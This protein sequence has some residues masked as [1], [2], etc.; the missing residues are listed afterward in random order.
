MLPKVLNT[1]TRKP[2]L[3]TLALQVLSD[4]ISDLCPI[5]TA[6]SGSVSSLPHQLPTIGCCAALHWP[7]R[8]QLPLHL[9]SEAHFPVWLCGPL[10]QAECVP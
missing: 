9:L 2:R 7:L 8:T 3:L 4:Q 5:S 6:G 1:L 10:L